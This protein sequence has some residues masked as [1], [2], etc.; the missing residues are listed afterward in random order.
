VRLLD[1]HQELDAHTEEEHQT[2][3]QV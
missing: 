1:P 2:R 3:G